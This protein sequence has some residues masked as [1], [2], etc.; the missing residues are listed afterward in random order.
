MESDHRN[1][2]RDSGRN[3][4]AKEEKRRSSPAAAT[5]GR[6]G[7]AR[8]V[9]HHFREGGRERES[10]T[11]PQSVNENLKSGFHFRNGKSERGRIARDDVHDSGTLV[12]A[13]DREERS[14]VIEISSPRDP[15]RLL[16]ALGEL[17]SFLSPQVREQIGPRPVTAPRPELSTKQYSASLN[18]RSLS[19]ARGHDPAPARSRD[20]EYAGRG[21]VPRSRSPL[22]FSESASERSRRTDGASYEQRH[23]QSA[24]R[25]ATWSHD[26][27]GQEVIELTAKLEELERQLAEEKREKRAAKRALL[28]SKQNV[29]ELVAF[30]GCLTHALRMPGPD[31]RY[32]ATRRRS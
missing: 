17:S 32:P 10:P 30:R 20:W 27:I 6:V 7:A 12:K 26:R 21:T 2:L 13:E 25:R 16:G 3:G 14:K 5:R 23:S 24:S 28:L 31:T 29:S 8:V 11:R 15:S 18:R 19:P 9:S 1:R 22:W 4:V